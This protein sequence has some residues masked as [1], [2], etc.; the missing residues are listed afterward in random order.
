MKFT[1]VFVLGAISSTLAL[2]S[3]NQEKLYDLMQL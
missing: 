3:D 1:T 2:M